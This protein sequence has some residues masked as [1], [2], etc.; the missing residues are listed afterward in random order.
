MS[1]TQV[2]QFMHEESWAS[3]TWS[4]TFAGWRVLNLGCT[5]DWTQ[6]SSISGSKMACVNY[7]AFVIV[8]KNNLCVIFYTIFWFRQEWF[9]VLMSIL[10]VCRYERYFL[11]LYFLC[12][13]VCMKFWP[14]SGCNPF[15]QVHWFCRTDCWLYDLRYLDLKSCCLRLAFFP[16][17][18]LWLLS[19][20]LWF[21]VGSNLPA[22]FSY[23]MQQAPLRARWG[24]PVM[25]LRYQIPM[26]SCTTAP[27]ATSVFYTG[28]CRCQQTVEC[29]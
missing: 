9:D 18:Q 10:F 11:S 13:P 6:H 12:P 27:W 24:R 7:A 25:Q 19:L 8:I 1:L 15:T 4:W 23:V 22:G 3:V 17:A 29:D 28:R 26:W 14:I 21:A 2:F 5:S 16:G 20:W